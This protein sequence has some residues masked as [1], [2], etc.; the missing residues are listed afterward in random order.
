MRLLLGFHGQTVIPYS[1]SASINSHSETRR[2]T[3]LRKVRWSRI[4]LV[5]ANTFKDVSELP[6][7]RRDFISAAF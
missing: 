2:I 6:Q 5:R 3:R 1:V 7:S 4:T